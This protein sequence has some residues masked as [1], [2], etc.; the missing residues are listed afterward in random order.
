MRGGNARQKLRRGHEQYQ[1]GAGQGAGMKSGSSTP[2]RLLCGAVAAL[3]LTA[4]SCC[5]SVSNGSGRRHY[6]C[7]AAHNDAHVFSDGHASISAGASLDSQHKRRHQKGSKDGDDPSG[8]GGGI[9]CAACWPDRSDFACA[10]RAAV[11]EMW[12]KSACHTLQLVCTLTEV[13]LCRFSIVSWVMASA[14]VLAP[15]GVS[16]WLHLKLHRQIALVL[17]R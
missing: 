12:C 15:L 9:S 10:H 11:V 6:N 8:G 17:A 4:D 5:C 1:H 16:A 7:T 13:E 14:L 2:L 3:S